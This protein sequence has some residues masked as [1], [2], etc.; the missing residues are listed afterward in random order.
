MKR[1]N[2]FERT[3]RDIT[4]ALLKVMESKSLEKISVQ[5][6]LDVAMVSRS[7]FYQHFRTNTPFWSA[8]RRNTSLG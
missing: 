8:C 1:V 7:T 4:N 2:Q 3:D 6:I 5:D